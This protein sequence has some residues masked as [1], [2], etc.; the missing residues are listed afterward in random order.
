MP[1]DEIAKI[2]RKYGILSLLSFGSLLTDE[3]NS[4]TSDADFV[5]DFGRE[6]GK[7]CIRNVR[8]E[9]AY[10]L[11]REVDLFSMKAISRCRFPKVRE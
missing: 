2:C 11:G 7:G 8:S 4:A 9:L 10:L 5:A 6:V 3:F 1:L